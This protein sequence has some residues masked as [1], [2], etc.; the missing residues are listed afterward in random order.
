MKTWNDR[1]KYARFVMAAA[2]GIS[3]VIQM[4]SKDYTHAELL[5]GIAALLMN[6]IEG[7]K[8]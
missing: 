7:P 5:I 1:A 8:C 6:S 3:G 4:L 2:L